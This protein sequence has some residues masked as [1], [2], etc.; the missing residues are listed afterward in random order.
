MSREG[1]L[2]TQS[3]DG[4]TER[5]DVLD[6]MRAS[7][8]RYALL[9]FI[10]GFDH[11]TADVNVQCIAARRVRLRPNEETCSARG[12]YGTSP[13]RDTAIQSTCR[14]TRGADRSHVVVDHNIS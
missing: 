8:A 13:R 7:P 11:D 14:C 3:N 4:K 1:P 10:L 6:A 9:P 2:A 5:D 12:T